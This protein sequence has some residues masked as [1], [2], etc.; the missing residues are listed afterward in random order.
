ME[1]TLKAHPREG[2][3]KGPARRL[4][5]Q[6]LVP[7]VLYG[8]GMAPRSLAV[9]GKDLIHLF[10]SSG[11]GSV[12]VDLDV[13]GDVHLALLR[14][15]QRDHLHGRYIHVDFLVVNRDEKV[16][17]LAEFR[18]FGEARGVREGGVVEHHLREVE[19]ECVPGDVPEA[20][21]IDISELEIGDLLRVGDITPPAGVTFL[22]DADTPVI[23]VVTPA[24]LRVE[25]DL[26]V[27]G[28][29]P[30]EGE[31]PAE[32]AEEEPAEGEA[33]PAEG[34]EAAPEASAES[35]G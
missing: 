1:T 31:A 3:G 29:A 14:D 18:E 13:D 17:M 16:R 11:G 21:E 33:T 15:V 24:A 2:S 26:S 28:E 34:G 23:S 9:S 20:I 19:I 22:T 32:A 5:A 25:A 6:G 8:H 35:E 4:R 30:V 10:H 27:P 7:A 12:I